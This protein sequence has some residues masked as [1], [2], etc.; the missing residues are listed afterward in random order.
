MRAKWPEGGLTA[1]GFRS[2][3]SAPPTSRDRGTSRGRRAVPRGHPARSAGITAAARPDAGS[4]G[5]GMRRA[6]RRHA[7]GGAE[8]GPPGRATATMDAEKV[9]EQRGVAPADA[10]GFA[11]GLDDQVW[12]ASD[13]VSTEPAP[14][15]AGGAAAS[16]PSIRRGS[17]TNSAWRTTSTDWTTDDPG[18]AGSAPPG[19][20]VA[21]I[22]PER[23]AR[24]LGSGSRSLGDPDERSGATSREDEDRR[25]FL[26]RYADQPEGL[27]RPHLIAD[28]ATDAR[29]A[30]L[31]AEAPN[32]AALIDIARRAALLSRHA[33][34]PLRLPPVLV[35]GPP[36]T[37]KSRIGRRLAEA[38]GTTLTVIDGG[39]TTDRGPFVGHD[40]GYRGSGPGK[41]ASALLDG[42][43]AGPLV[44]L[45]EVDKVS[46]YIAGVRPLDA[47]LNLLEPTTARCFVDTYLGLPLR[48]EGVQWLMTANSTAGLPAPLLDRVVVVEMPPLGS[49]GTRDA[50]RRMLAEL[51]AEHGLPAAALGD[52]A[53]D[54]LQRAGMRQARRTLSLALGPALAAGH[55]APDAADIAGASALLDRPARRRRA[56]PTPKRG[57]VGFVHFPSGPSGEAARSE[58]PQPR[59]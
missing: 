10:D 50:L 52:A 51:Q 11:A 15:D 55:A 47:L 17:D 38:L 9:S 34:S 18:A 1:S 19:P 54:R 22:D 46:S 33:G 28:A 41:I 8:C 49:A 57:P 32:A 6:L 29:L 7:G 27:F 37:G 2:R 21:L 23:L 36:G 56:P 20:G 53:L 42:R 14:G 31:R 44:L 39:T 58:A 59:R 43:T 30:A 5:A 48:A 3:T 24:Q 13:P 25:D 16:P 45:D 26:R 40:P 12:T 35:V 4:G